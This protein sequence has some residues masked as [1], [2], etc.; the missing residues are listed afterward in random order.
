MES[1]SSIKAVMLVGGTGEVIA[2][3]RAQDDENSLSLGEGL[4]MMVQIP[5]PRLLA[6][7]RIDS[8]RAR[9]RVYQKV[10]SLVGFPKG[11]ITS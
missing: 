2:H 6:Y 1:D 5:N 9:Q 3:G 10:L 11:Y 7:L 4:P 8:G